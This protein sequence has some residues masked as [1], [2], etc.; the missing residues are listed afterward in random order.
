MTS[1]E[2]QKIAWCEYNDKTKTIF[3][4]QRIAISQ[5]REIPVVWNCSKVEDKN[6]NGIARYTFKQDNWNEHTDYKEYDEDGNL[7]GIWCN[8][9]N[10]EVTPEPPSPIQENIYSKITYS[11]TKPE[12]KI[13]GSYKKFTVTFYKDDEP[14][15]LQHGDWKFTIDN[16]D[17]SNLVEIDSS[18]VKSNQ[19][20]VRFHADDTYIGKVLDVAF[21]S[22]M[23]VKSSVQINIV[24][25]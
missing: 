3:Y 1:P 10:G 23:G 2:N 22:Y 9:F 25:T 6:E 15:E 14:I 11:G 13:N 24:G 5:D 12:I 20:K 16:L 18:N 19:I 21:E 8:W 4:D 7:I 17:V